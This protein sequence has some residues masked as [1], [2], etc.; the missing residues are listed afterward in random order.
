MSSLYIMRYL[1]ST[2]IGAGV[3]Y[4]GKGQILGTD[5]GAFRYQGTYS[6]DG[7][8]LR[9]T[10]TLT[11]STEATLVT[12]TEMRKGQSLNISADWPDN[13]ADGSPQTANIGG[14]LVQVTFEKIG[15]IP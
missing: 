5:V 6:V 11:A 7:G 2:G 4:I 10:A 12:G 15:N 14:M 3:L 8:R 9:A 1:G 13:F